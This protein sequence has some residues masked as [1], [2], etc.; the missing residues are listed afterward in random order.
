MPNLV[1]PKTF[2]IAE[3]KLD[4]TGLQEA[5]YELNV[6]EWTTDAASDAEHLIEFSGKMC[7]A[8]LDKAM[9]KN[10]TRVGTRNNHDYIQ[11]QIIKTGHGSVI[12]HATVSFLLTNVSRVLT[13]EIC[14]HRAGT[15]F[16]Q[17]SGRFVRTDKIGFWAPSVIKN[18]PW[19]NNFFNECFANMETWVK[20]LEEHYK[21]DELTGKD[22]FTLKKILTSAFR[23]VI[24]NGQSNHIV[25]TCN[26]RALRHMIEM[27]TDIHAEEEIRIVFNQMFN[28]VK[29]RYPALYADAVVT[30]DQN[31]N[32]LFSVKFR[33]RKV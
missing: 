6:P 4:K 21:I 9:N 25:I 33:G 16:S 26:H 31:D 10:L 22:G 12:E 18:D 7:Y 13:H 8:S 5:L 24:G 27:R 20:Q 30:T 32:K 15:A 14:R 3:T 23:R 19:A 17:I 2:L 11:E 28:Q 29:D 1:E